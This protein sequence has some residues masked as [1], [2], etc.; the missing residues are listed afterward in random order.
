MDIP[1]SLSETRS[2]SFWTIKPVQYR[3]EVCSV[4]I[5]QSP[6]DFG[7]SKN[8]QDLQRYTKDTRK[9]NGFGAGDLPLHT[10][11]ITTLF[12]NKDGPGVGEIRSFLEEQ[13][14]KFPLSTLTS[15]S[16]FPSGLDE[17]VHDSL[18][19]VPLEIGGHYTLLMD[20]SDLAVMAAL[21]GSSNGQ[22]LHAAYQWVAGG[23]L[24]YLETPRVTDHHITCVVRL[25]DYSSHGSKIVLSCKENPA[26]STPALGFRLRKI[27]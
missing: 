4:D 25:D 23:S 18:Q 5:S 19:A 14:H 26:T 12:R 24:P 9:K 15:V 27:S 16:Y 3:N 17:I 21:T 20:V 1:F 10:A 2:I 11:V 8:M 7:A 22:E 13:L 6:V